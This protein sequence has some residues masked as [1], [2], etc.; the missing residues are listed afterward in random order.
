[1][2]ETVKNLVERVIEAEF[3]EVQYLNFSDMTDEEKKEH[4][5]A[6]NKV[7]E[8]QD[9]FRGILSQEQ[10]KLFIEYSDT[11]SLL[12]TIEQIYMFNHGVKA[13]FN[14]L[15]YIREELGEAVIML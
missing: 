15:N 7:L 8:L 11:F 9:K 4:D 5:E 12:S 6:Y 14:K 10:W 13:G 3:N 1:M 2:N